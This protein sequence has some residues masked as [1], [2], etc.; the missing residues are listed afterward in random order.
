MSGRTSAPAHKSANLDEC[1]LLAGD[2]VQLL[3][4]FAASSVDLTLSD[5]PYGISLAEWDVLH[6]NTN[7]A[8]GGQSPAQKT[9]GPRFKRRGKPING[10]SKADLDRPKEYEDWCFSWATQLARVMRPGGS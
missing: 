6:S 10:W 8:L 2:C 7:S 3:A 4:T 9:M 1:R 5:M